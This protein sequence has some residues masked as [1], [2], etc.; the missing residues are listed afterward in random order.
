M[1]PRTL[2]IFDEVEKIPEGIVGSLSVYMDHHKNVNG[3]DFR[4]ATFI[5]LSNSGGTAIAHRLLELVQMGKLR[6]DTK[7]HEFED[8]LELSAYNQDGG[9]KGTNLLQ[10]S[11]IDHFIPFLPLEQRHIEQCIRE[12]F[13]ARNK[14]ANKNTIK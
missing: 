5:F 4:Q 11:L 2:F 9:L 14:A 13:N 3:L 10:Q 7:F 6:E 8:V 1:C 12:E